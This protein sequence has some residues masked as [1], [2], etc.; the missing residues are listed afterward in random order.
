MPPGEPLGMPDRKGAF[1]VAGPVAAGSEGLAGRIAPAADAA[2][3]NPDTQLRG[4]SLG[5]VLRLVVAPP[6]PPERVQGQRDHDLDIV[7][8]PAL[9]E[10][11]PVPRAHLPGHTPR[12]AILEAVNQP[13]PAASV[14][15]EK[16]SRGPFDG[17]QPPAFARDGIVGLVP[18][19]GQGRR[20]AAEG[21]DRPFAACE[22]LPA[23]RA[24]GREQQ[25]RN[26]AQKVTE[27][28][29]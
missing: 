5:E 28:R 8:K 3:V 14:D 18:V 1:D 23:D 11:P 15:E 20:G 26:V 12:P 29:H 25:R 6:A 16:E 27:D 7:V 21:A 4:D 19:A 9:P 2:A 22:R 24:A 10:M 17:H 13:P